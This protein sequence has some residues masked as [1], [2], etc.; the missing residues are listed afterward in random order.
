MAWKMQQKLDQHLTSIPCVDEELAQQRALKNRAKPSLTTWRLVLILGD[1]LLLLFALILLLVIA[2]ELHL[3]LSIRWSQPGTWENK[4][5]WGALALAAWVV[6][7]H[8]THAENLACAS[9]SLKSPLMATFTL[10]LV[11]F[12]WLVPTSPFIADRL[13]PALLTLLLFLLIA[14]PFFAAWRVVLARIMNQTRF[15]RRA[16]IVGT[17]AVGELIAGEI[18]QAPWARIDILGFID[19]NT[20]DNANNELPVLHDRTGLHLLAQRR[21]VDLLIMALD[22]A[23]NKQLIQELILLQQAHVVVQPAIQLYESISGK[24]PLAY[25]G[26]HWYTLLPK[27]SVSPLYFLWRQFL[28]LVFALIGLALLV[29]LF[30]VL[31]LLMK[32]DSP[33]PIF[34]RQER[35]GWNGQVFL[36]YKFRSMHVDAEQGGQAHWAAKSDTR[37]TRIGRFLRS[38]HL[39]ELPQV[40]NILRGEMSLIG[41]RPERETFVVELEKTIPFYRCRLL[42]KPGL[43]GWAQVKYRYARSGQEAYEKLQ[44]DLYYIKHQSFLLDVLILFKTVAE[45]LSCRGS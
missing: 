31:A 41:P 29:C 24:T 17:N 42:I 37:V 33:G 3:G 1:G 32:L 2:P 19:E 25:I 10:L 9:D 43:S 23:T 28:D 18:K 34:Y 7:L 45:V 11:V 14:I 35:L 12:F 21:A 30:P 8:L 22:Y 5:I 44:Y 36:I 27:E 15:R 20:P 13:G 38:S 6:A 4:L 40:L 39:D 16:L 26:E